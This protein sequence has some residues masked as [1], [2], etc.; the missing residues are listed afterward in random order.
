[1]LELPN[2]GPNM[3]ADDIL[4]GIMLIRV[5]V[6]LVHPAARRYWHDPVGIAMRYYC[7]NASLPCANTFPPARETPYNSLPW[8][9]TICPKPVR[10]VLSPHNHQEKCT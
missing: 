3:T 8:V 6:A 5:G 10:S 4:N 9:N 1:M 7:G 2:H